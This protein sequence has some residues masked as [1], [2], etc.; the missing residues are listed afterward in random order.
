VGGI[1]SNM[2]IGFAETIL[3]GYMHLASLEQ[4][5]CCG[6]SVQ[7]ASFAFLSTCLSPC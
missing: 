7:F 1:A 5:A 6:W 4:I 3:Y 2:L